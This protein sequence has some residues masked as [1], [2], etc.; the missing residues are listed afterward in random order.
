MSVNNAKSIT[1]LVVFL[2]TQILVIFPVHIPIPRRFFRLFKLKNKSK[3]DEKSNT[4]SDFRFPLD[5]HTA[6]VI[7]VLLLLA[8]GCIHGPEVK[9]GIVGADGVE[10][11]NVMALFISLAYMAISVDK[12]GLLRFLAFWV[13]SRSGTSGIRLYI[14]IYSFFFTLGVVVGNDPVIL[15]GVPFLAYFTQEMQINPPTAWIF[16]QFVIANIASAVLVSSNPTNL[17]L[18]GAFSIS[19]FTYTA[20]IIVPVVV[21]AIIILP[22]LLF[23]FRKPGLIP[24]EIKPIALSP[25]SVLVDPFGGIF[26]GTLLILT[27]CTLVGTSIL[28]PQ[29]F[30]VTVPPAVIVFIRDVLYDLRR[31]R[32]QVRKVEE[33]PVP[34]V[35]KPADIELDTRKR[36]ASDIEMANETVE[37][38]PPTGMLSHQTSRTLIVPQEELGGTMDLQTRPTESPAKLEVETTKVHPEPNILFRMF[39]TVISILKLMPF[40]LVLFSLSMFILVQGLGVNGWVDVWAHWWRAWVHRTGAVGTIFGMGLVSCILCNIFGTNIGATILL[41]RVLQTW[42]ESSS[43][44]PRIKDGA[45]FALALGSNYGAFTFSFPASLAG[46]LWRRLLLQK[47]IKVTMLQFARLNFIPVAVAMAVSSAVLVGQVCIVHR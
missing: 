19:Y 33:N 30:L 10:P 20:K 24:R 31:Y 44:S 47:N 18:S 43:P 28:H 46:L 38:Y 39:P 32:K 42:I 17:V 12:A 40:S 6:P 3:H 29:V 45:I 4:R 36:Q 1:T 9:R 8:A 41:A 5:F 21:A 27:L 22:V 25:R 26:G 11:L 37:A 34:I 7:A 2:I 13:A 35:E 16:G 23:L 14:A 15:S